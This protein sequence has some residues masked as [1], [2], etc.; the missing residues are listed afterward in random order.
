ML[1][2]NKFVSGTVQTSVNLFHLLEPSTWD[3]EHGQVPWKEAED[4]LEEF[5]EVLHHQINVNDF[6][7]FV[8]DAIEG[9][10]RKCIRKSTQGS[11]C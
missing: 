2:Q 5:S 1:A 11:Y 10:N 4:K 7:D 3:V 6:R 8:E 9:S